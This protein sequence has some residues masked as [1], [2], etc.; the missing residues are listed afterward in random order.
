MSVNPSEPPSDK[1][2]GEPTLD[3]SGLPEHASAEERQREEFANAQKEV[4]AMRAK[5]EAA[6]EKSAK[7]RIDLGQAQDRIEEL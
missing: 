2:V 7:V 6:E 1:D 5:L 4:E 3:S